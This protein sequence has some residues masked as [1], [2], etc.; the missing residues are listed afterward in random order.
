MFIHDKEERDRHHRIERDYDIITV[1]FR[2]KFKQSVRITSTYRASVWKTVK[3]FFITPL[4]KLGTKEIVHNVSHVTID[5]DIEEVPNE[6][7]IG[8]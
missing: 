7:I 3:A 4:S 6:E 8:S 5:T 2:G 1:S